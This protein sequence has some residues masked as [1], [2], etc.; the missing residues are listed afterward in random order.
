[1]AIIK[2]CDLRRECPITYRAYGIAM[3][4]PRAA[5]ELAEPCRLQRYASKA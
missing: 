3:N 5:T 4:N 2:H 1:M